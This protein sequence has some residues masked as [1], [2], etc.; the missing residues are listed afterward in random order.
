MQ[1][2]IIFITNACGCRPQVGVVQFRVVQLKNKVAFLGVAFPIV[3]T[4]KARDKLHERDE[5]QNGECPVCFDHMPPFKWMC[6]TCSNAICRPCWNNLP[7]KACVHCRAVEERVSP[8][9]QF[10][11]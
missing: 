8:L 10:C 5:G 4:Q 3:L 9:T 7:H 11:D 1:L 6:A 2:P